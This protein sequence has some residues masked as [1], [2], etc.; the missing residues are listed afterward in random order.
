MIICSLFLLHNIEILVL[1]SRKPLHILQNA[2]TICTSSSTTTTQTSILPEAEALESNEGIGNEKNTVEKRM[3]KRQDVMKSACHRLG[4]DKHGND[5]LHQVKPWEYFINRKYNLVWCN[6][7]KSAS[8]SW[9]YILNV[10][11]GYTPEYLDSSKVVPLNL[12]RAKYP[13]PSASE[14]ENFMNLQQNVTSMIIGRHPL[15]RLVSAYREKIVGA[16]PGTLHDKL[17]RRITQDYRPAAVP[18]VRVLPEKYIPTFTEFAQY[19]VREHN[20][21]KEPEMHWAPVYS[22]CNPCQVTMNTILKIETLEEDTQYVLNKIKATKLLK[23]VKQKNM[24]KGGSSHDAAAMFLKQLDRKLF[25]ELVKI[26]K[27][28]FLIFGY[29]IPKYESYLQV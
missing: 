5:V 19:L 7:F 13:R 6:V 28:D 9:M 10:L 18:R 26:Y 17:R 29:G 24:S 1:K 11:A 20:K 27:F 8:T 14:L 22:F 23:T 25:N 4:L 21:E 12:A 15:E 16:R 2:V 3:R